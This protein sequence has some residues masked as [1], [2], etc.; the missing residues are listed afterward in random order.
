MWFL[1]GTDWKHVSEIIINFLKTR[2]FQQNYRDKTV[3]IR[4]FFWFIFSCVWTECG[5]LLLD[6]MWKFTPWISKFSPS[7]RKQWPEK[8]LYLH[9][10]HTVNNLLLVNEWMNAKHILPPC[11]FYNIF[12]VQIQNLFIVYI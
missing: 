6:W 11:T 10:F 8:A 3:Q 4:S 9:T 5:D 7:T 1:N 2:Y 12:I